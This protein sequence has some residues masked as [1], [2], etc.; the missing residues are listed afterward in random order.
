[1]EGILGIKSIIEANGLVYGS[2]EGVASRSI[3][4][5]RERGHAGSGVRVQGSEGGGFG[6]LYDVRGLVTSVSM[7][8]ADGTAWPGDFSAPASN[9]ATIAG[10]QYDGGNAGGD[11]LLSSSTAY[12][13]G[14]GNH[15]RTTQYAFDWRDRLETT[16]TSDGTT[17][18]IDKSFHDNLGRVTEQIRYRGSID[19]GNRIGDSLASY[20]NLGRVFQTT[21]FGVDPAN[22]SESSGSLVSNFWFDPAG[23]VIKSQ[24]GGTQQ[25]TKSVYDGLNR[26]TSVYVGYDTSEGSFSAA[27]NVAG[28]TI[29]QQTNAQYDAASHLT[30][31]TSFD[32]YRDASTSDTGALD[33]LG[34]TDSRASYAAYWFDGIGRQTAVQDFGATASVPSRSDDQPAIDSSGATRVSLTNYNSRGEVWQ[35]F[36][37]AGNE[38]RTF[39][40][41]TGRTIEKIQ[42]Y[43]TT[44]AAD[45]N[46]TTNYA[47]NAGTDLLSAMSVTTEKADLSDT[48][49]QITAYVYGTDTPYGSSPVIY[50]HDFVSAVIYGLSDINQLENLVSNVASGSTSTYNLVE[51]THNRQSE[52]TQMTDQNGT[53]HDYGFDGLGRQVSD[54]A[55]LPSGSAVDNQVLRIDTAYNLQGSIAS[56][57]SYSSTSGGSGNI[58]NQVA[59]S[60]NT[61]GLLADEKQSVSG[62]VTS[63]TPDVHYAYADGTA[64]PTRLTSITYPNGRELDYGYSSGTDAAVGRVSYL[65][66]SNNSTHLVDYYYLGLGQIDKV[67]SPEP[68]IVLDLGH[69]GTGGQLDRVDQFN[70]VTDQIFAETGGN[71]DEIKYGYDISGNRKWKIEQ[72]AADNSVYLDELYGYNALNELT[73]TARGQLITA[74]DAI[75]AHASLTEGWTLDGM[76][77]WSNYS[78]SGG[79]STINQDR[80]TNALN[81]ITGYNSTSTWAV[82]LYDAAGNMTTMPQP[83]NETAGLTCKYDAWNRLVKVQ[84]GETTLATYSYD[85]LNRRVTETA[86]GNTRAH[87][88]SDADQVL[89][90]RV[91]SSPLPL[92]EGQSEGEFIAALPADRQYVWGL[93]YV[94]DL[95]LRDRDNGT[96][97]NLGKSGFGLGE[98]LYAL[99]DANWNVVAKGRMERRHGVFQDRFVKA[100]RLKKIDSLEGGN[101]FLETEF[102]DELNERFHVEARSP[103]DLHRSV[104]RGVK[105][106]HVLSY[107]EQR[108]VQNDWTVSWYNRI[109]QI[110]ESHRKLTLTRKKILVSELLD[111]QIRL[112]HRGL[113]LPWSELPERPSTAKPKR[114]QTGGT[115]KQKPAATHPWR[116]PFLG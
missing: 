30:L 24:A 51:Y 9:M 109:F 85:G 105:L 56:T 3:L 86:G 91:S 41:D 20:D 113:D 87:Y 25:F 60:Y 81:E 55:T 97:G 94:D 7:G 16:T 54:S 101:H 115:A 70:R 11:G 39:Y 36:D 26:P 90:E 14:T 2:I 73:S 114:Y 44:P 15:D 47:F 83:G 45:K 107:Q 68:G 89:E 100:L 22:G 78:Q 10:Y 17:T 34:A 27:G 66:D 77:N 61:F 104:P 96:G 57:T 48:Q 79:G 75:T 31:A 59:D 84:S 110:R 5:H 58:V 37:P 23:N 92:G 46:I 32:R 111:G 43:S 33:L 6:T 53:Q 62:S 38:Y 13:D 21:V 8:T 116:R 82:P 95:I 28:D 49:T 35:T 67:S 103:T 1:M 74:H 52:V 71:I 108:T 76:G 69:K 19:V 4:Q 102:L 88:Y 65:K 99:Q 112:T 29:L 64:T 42:N 18:F 106:E 40:D 12:T 93:R 63:G 72:T 50:R 80:N 98:R